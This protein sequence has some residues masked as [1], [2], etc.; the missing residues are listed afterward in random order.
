[1]RKT[2]RTQLAALALGLAVGFAGGCDPGDA[3]FL[4]G[5]GGVADDTVCYEDNDCTPNACCGEGTSMV[6]VSNG[7]SCSGVVCPGD[8]YP[9]NTIN[10]GACIPYCRDARCVSNACS[11]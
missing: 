9:S 3:E 6:H 4:G 11:N 1:M 7:P 10:Q 8:S 2:F 5:G